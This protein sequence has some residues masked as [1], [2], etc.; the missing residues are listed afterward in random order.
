M[1]IAFVIAG[2]VLAA[3]VYGYVWLQMTGAGFHDYEKSLGNPDHANAVRVVQVINAIIGF[4]LPAVVAASMLNRRPFRLLGFSGPVRANQAGLA[5]LIMLASLIVSGALSYVN[6]QLPIPASWRLIFDQLEEDY[7]RR[8]AAIVGLKSI[9]DYI[10][11]LVIMGLLPALCEET[12]FRGGLQNFLSRATNNPWLSIVVVSILFSIVHF[13]FYGFLYRVFLGMVLGALFH[14]SG[15]LWPSILAH[16]LNNAIVLTVLYYYTLQG[17][18]ISETMNM[19]APGL[20][21]VLLLPVVI[22]LFIFFKRISPVVR[23]SE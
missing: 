16:F 12:L 15:K 17:K 20:W 11:S 18:P 4:L 13:S 22:G 21:G 1:T 9:S 5:V 10:I 23:R 8:A 6:H 19:E 2:L 14:Y 7:N 3:Q